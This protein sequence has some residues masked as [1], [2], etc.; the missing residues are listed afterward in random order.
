MNKPGGVLQKG[1]GRGLKVCVC[2]RVP[3]YKCHYIVSSPNQRD[4]TVLFLLHLTP[5]REVS[6]IR[7]VRRRKCIH[8]STRPPITVMNRFLFKLVR[9]GSMKQE[10]SQFSDFKSN[11]EREFFIGQK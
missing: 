2:Q 1:H 4:I 3:R 5:L 7:S 9:S 8:Q 10:G 6:Q 11:F